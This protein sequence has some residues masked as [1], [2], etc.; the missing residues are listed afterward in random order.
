VQACLKYTSLFVLLLVGLMP[1]SAGDSLPPQLCASVNLSVTLDEPGTEHREMA[2]V[3]NPGD[4]IV[5]SVMGNFASSNGTLSYSVDGF[6]EN[7]FVSPGVRFDV[8]MNASGV[9]NVTFNF[10]LMQSGVQAVLAVFC[11]PA[12]S[13][14]DPE[15]PTSALEG[16]TDRNPDGRLNWGVCDQAVVVYPTQ[17]PNGIA[18]Y[19]IVPDASAASGAAG[20]FVFFAALSDVQPILDAVPLNQHVLVKQAG[21]AALYVQKDTGFIQINI[22]QSG[23][24]DFCTFEMD[25]LNP[26]YIAQIEPSRR[27][28]PPPLR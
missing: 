13:S 4:V 16:S 20:R 18:V 5:F 25:S 17:N 1:A 23:D 21:R 3:V 6:G 28:G 22:G 9:A 27:V 10:S 12:V 26:S 24:A 7:L 19:E 11:I 15:S 2:V 14:A 8:V